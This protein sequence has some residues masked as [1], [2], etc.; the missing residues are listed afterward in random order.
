[1]SYHYD[2]DDYD[3][4]GAEQGRAEQKQASRD[5]VKISV[6]DSV[7]SETQCGV[8]VLYIYIPHLHGRG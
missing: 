1:M 8:G 2:D 6:R 5:N 4:A 7:R 3:D